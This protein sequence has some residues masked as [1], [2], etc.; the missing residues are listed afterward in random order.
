MLPRLYSVPNL[1]QLRSLT[2]DW[3][4]FE[5]VDEALSGRVH[6]MLEF[7]VLE[8]L[9]V[10]KGNKGWWHNQRGKFEG[11]VSIVVRQ[12]R[13]VKLIDIPRRINMIQIKGF[14]RGESRS[15]METQSEVPGIEMNLK[16]WILYTI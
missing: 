7:P 13:S 4:L 8:Q 6:Q 16:G 11:E 14:P 2:C 1:K 9:L 10:L 12:R 15:E 5:K 3:R